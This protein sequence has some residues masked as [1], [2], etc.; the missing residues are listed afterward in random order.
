MITLKFMIHKKFLAD[1]IDILSPIWCLLFKYA[2]Q[3]QRDYH[4]TFSDALSSSL[5]Y[6]LKSNLK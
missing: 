2:I 1:E 5:S 6:L 4:F 3:R